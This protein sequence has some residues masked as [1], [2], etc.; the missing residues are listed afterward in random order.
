MGELSYSLTFSQQLQDAITTKIGRYSYQRLDL[1]AEAVRDLGE[2][3]FEHGADVE[4]V[5]SVVI[6]DTS[7]PP[8]LG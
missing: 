3:H 7:L 8:N 2:A 5:H 4:S 6:V 1:P